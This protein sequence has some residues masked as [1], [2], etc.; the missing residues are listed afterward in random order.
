M[1]SSVPHDAVRKFHQRDHEQHPQPLFSYSHP[2]S[3]I[4]LH[5]YMEE[6]LRLATFGMSPQQ[7]RQVLPLL[8]RIIVGVHIALACGWLSATGFPGFAKATDVEELRR[9]QMDAATEVVAQNIFD[10]RVRQCQA[11]TDEARRFYAER[12]QML[13]AKYVDI[14]QREY[15]RVPGCGEL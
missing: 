12:L 10:T 14:T 4:A 3:F 7:R 5:N 9:G 2:W 13:L 15:N 11:G 1:A 8:W 6:F